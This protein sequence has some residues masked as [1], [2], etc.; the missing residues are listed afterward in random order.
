MG[1][2][3][4]Q[5]PLE[6]YLLI[7]VSFTPETRVRKTRSEPNKHP[8][9]GCAIFDGMTVNYIEKAPAQFMSA[10]CGTPSVLAA[11]SGI[12]KQRYVS[13]Y[14]VTKV[15]VR[16]DLANIA[17]RPR[18][19]RLVTSPDDHSPSVAAINHGRCSAR[20]VVPRDP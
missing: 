14:V 20:Y 15:E 19:S 5:S 4:I 16:S 9:R 6:V 1:S 7:E 17:F 18:E 12:P 13:S 11:G 3:R 8:L 2:T 10:E